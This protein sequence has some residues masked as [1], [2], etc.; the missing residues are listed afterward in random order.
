V[1]QVEADGALL[2][3]NEINRG[4]VINSPDLARKMAELIQEDTEGSAAVE[5]SRPYSVE[6]VG[7]AWHVKANPTAIGDW[8]DESP[9]EIIIQKRDARVLSLGRSIRPKLSLSSLLRPGG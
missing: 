2:L 8:E 7:T 6:D 5:R 1:K 9:W 4:G 3:L